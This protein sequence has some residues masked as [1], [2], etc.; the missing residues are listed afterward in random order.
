MAIHQTLLCNPTIATL[1]CDLEQII[2][3]FHLQFPCLENG[4][5]DDHR[6]QRIDAKIKWG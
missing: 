3:P 2:F 4:T 6:P 5:N 1:Q